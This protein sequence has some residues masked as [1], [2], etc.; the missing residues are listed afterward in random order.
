MEFRLNHFFI[1][2][3]FIILSLPGLWMHSGV[4]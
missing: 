2:V 4:V 1:S 3:E